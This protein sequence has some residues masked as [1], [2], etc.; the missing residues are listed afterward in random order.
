MKILDKEKIKEYVKY[1]Y[2]LLDDSK[3]KKALLNYSQLRG[4]GVIEDIWCCFANEYEEWEE[5]YFRE[6]GIAFYFDYPAVKEDCYIILENKE[7][8]QYLVEQ[9][10]EYINRRPNDKNEIEE[11]LKI[12]SNKLNLGLK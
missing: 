3:F 7:F 5:D 11:L 8:Y 9:C 10:E 1:Y 4:Y 6:S 2:D 12:I